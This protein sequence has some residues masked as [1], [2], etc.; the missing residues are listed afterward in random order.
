MHKSTLCVVCHSF[1][2]VNI[3]PSVFFSVA[4]WQNHSRCERVG[5]K[6]DEI[7]SIGSSF[8]FLN[9]WCVCVWFLLS[10]ALSLWRHP[11]YFLYSRKIHTTKS[12]FDDKSVSAVFWFWCCYCTVGGSLREYLHVF[13]IHF[14]FL[15]FLRFF[16]GD[17]WSDL[18]PDWMHLKSYGTQTIDVRKQMAQVFTF[19]K[20][21]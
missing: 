10:N 2:I 8:S 5:K 6:M 15:S 1:V 20:P 11:L 18:S 3:Y 7:S 4:K 9:D 12:Y 16:D 17:I 13:H 14:L 19:C 21:H